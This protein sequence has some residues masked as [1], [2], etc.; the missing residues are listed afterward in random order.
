MILQLQHY[1]CYVT[2]TITRSIYL[3]CELEKLEKE[4]NGSES[5]NKSREKMKILIR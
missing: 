5:R 3:N 2:Y 1:L 4:E